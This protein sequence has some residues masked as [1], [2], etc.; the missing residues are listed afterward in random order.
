MA[1]PNS[2]NKSSSSRPE[3]LFIDLALNAQQEREMK[4]K[5]WAKTQWFMF[6]DQVLDNGYKLS[7]KEDTRNGSVMIL[8][9]NAEYDPDATPT[10][11]VMRSSSAAGALLKLSYYWMIS[12]ATLP[13]EKETRAKEESDDA[14]FE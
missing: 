11:W 1:K 3:V 2:R 14:L 4:S 6:I 12:D 8:L 13:D 7:I 5:G 10:F 9:Q